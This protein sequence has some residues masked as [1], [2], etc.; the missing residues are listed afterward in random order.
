VPKILGNLLVLLG[1]KSRSQI[2]RILKDGWMD[3]YVSEVEGTKYLKM[4]P[5]GKPR[6]VVHMEGIA[7]WRPNGVVHG[8]R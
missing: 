3:G 4:K 1:Y 2:Y 6:L 5:S 7:Q 8:S